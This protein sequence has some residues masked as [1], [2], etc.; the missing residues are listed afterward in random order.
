[1]K[2]LP[3]V[4][5]L[6]SRENDLSDQ[7]KRFLET[8]EEVDH[9]SDYDQPVEIESNHVVQ[10]HRSLGELVY[11]TGNAEELAGPLNLGPREVVDRLCKDGLSSHSVVLSAYMEE[12]DYE[13]LPQTLNRLGHDLPTVESRL[14]KAEFQYTDRLPEIA[15]RIE[16]GERRRKGSSPRKLAEAEGPVPK[17]SPVYPDSLVKAGQKHL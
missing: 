14:R 4:R 6:L 11:A 8:V 1:M 10:G 3:G 7:E 2:V 15:Y 9:P 13:S 16:V 17:P 5:N 12:E